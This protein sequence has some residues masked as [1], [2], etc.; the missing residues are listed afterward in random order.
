MMIRG[1]YWSTSSIGNEQWA[2]IKSIDTEQ[3]AN[4]KH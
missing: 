1:G 4:G 3:L 2:N